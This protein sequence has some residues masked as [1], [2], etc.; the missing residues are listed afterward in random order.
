MHQKALGLNST[1]ASV[2][3]FFQKTAIGKSIRKGDDAAIE[4]EHARIQKL[5]DIAYVVCKTE[6]PPPGISCEG[7][8]S[9]N[10]SG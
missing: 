5:V 1:P 3:D 2:D 10:Q 9:G 4:A 8:F 6:K 7:C